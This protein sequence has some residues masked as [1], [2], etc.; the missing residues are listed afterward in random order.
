MDFN[1][2]TFMKRHLFAIIPALLILMLA[3]CGPV[4]DVIYLQD[5]PP[6]TELTLQ[7]DGDLRL[8]PGDKVSVNVYS[9]DPELASMFNLYSGGQSSAGGYNSGRGNSYYAYTVDTNGNI[10]MPIIGSI[11]VAGLTRLEVADLV[12]Y[13]LLSGSLLRDPVVIV[14]FPDMAFYVI[15][16]SG[17]GRHTFPDDKLTI[18][19]AIS[20][21]GDLTI[22][23][24]RRHVRVLRT[25]GKKQHTYEIDL[26]KADAVYD[27]PV[28]YV[29]QGDMIYIE[30]TQIKQNQA[31]ANGS[32]YMTPGFWV[33][34]LG[35]ASTLIVLFTK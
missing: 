23:G 6:N 21:S 32:S 20:L 7:S 33:S 35:L 26:T 15:G 31:S 24:K 1:T 13:R 5:L 11:H 27:S 10:D 17:V 18:L 28:Y 34:M 16:E 3:S 29:R 9:R 8:M 25:E 22:Q 12:K 19:E 4:K 14:N 2:T 30:P